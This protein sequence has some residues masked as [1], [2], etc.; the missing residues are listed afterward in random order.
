MDDGYGGKSG[1]SDSCMHFK[2]GVEIFWILGRFAAMIL[3]F[4]AL[5]FL[6]EATSTNL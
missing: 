1:F 5:S 4:D 6:Q 2:Y 3:T